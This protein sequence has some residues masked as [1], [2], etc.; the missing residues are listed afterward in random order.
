ME[1]MGVMEGCGINEA[2]N[3]VFLI[4]STD[5][6]VENPQEALREILKGNGDGYRIERVVVLRNPASPI[7]RSRH[8]LRILNPD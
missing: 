8:H 5:K 6:E 1:R 2:R 7:R 3:Y 4:F